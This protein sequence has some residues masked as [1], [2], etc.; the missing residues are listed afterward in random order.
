V[1]EIRDVSPADFDAVFYERL[2]FVTDQR[3]GIWTKAL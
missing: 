1:A 3:L 2:G